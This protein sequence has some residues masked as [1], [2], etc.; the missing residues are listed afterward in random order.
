MGKAQRKG[1]ASLPQIGVTVLQNR[2][3]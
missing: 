1:G 3:G 2:S